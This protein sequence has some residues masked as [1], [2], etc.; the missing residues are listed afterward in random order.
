MEEKMLDE[1]AVISQGKVRILIV[2]DDKA[3]R[4]LLSEY[5][6][7]YDFETT[8]AASTAEATQYLTQHTFDIIILDVMMP[9][10]TGIEFLRRFRQTS[11]TYVLMLTALDNVTQK[12]EGLDVGADDYLTKPF[13]PLELVARLRALLRR[14]SSSAPE[15][16]KVL[17]IGQ[18]EFHVKPGALLHQGSQV[19]LSSTEKTL[20]Q[21][22]AQRPLEPTSR[23]SLAQKMGHRVSERTIDVQINRL[24]QKLKAIDAEHETIL[25]VRH[26]GY[27]LNII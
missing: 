20:L 8:T 26:L 1:N 16:N 27:A 19:I 9:Q 22:L 11:Q 14:K 2:D 23:E 3:I 17:Y 12:I 18:F 15:E 7:Q 24:R 13:E 21:V 6:Q 5:L 4:N 25:T 10:E